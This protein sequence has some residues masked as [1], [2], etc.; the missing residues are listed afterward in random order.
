[1]NK[2]EKELG[3]KLLIKDIESFELDHGVKLPSSII[4]FY[5][6]NNGGELKNKFKYLYPQRDVGIFPVFYIMPLVSPLYEDIESVEDNIN[7]LRNIN[8]SYKNY[9]PIA[10]DLFG[11]Y[12]VVSLLNGEV[13]WTDHE[14]PNE[15]VLFG[16]DI[17]S[18]I[19][20][21]SEEE[22]S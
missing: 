6:E 16:N 20:S 12:I 1:M 9:M 5:L 3:K 7:F 18:F 11:N 15:F 13:Y 19:N 17:F 2:I 4:D 14:D 21:L 8:E 10:L 22:P